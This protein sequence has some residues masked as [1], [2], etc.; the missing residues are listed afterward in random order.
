MLTSVLCRARRKN[1]KKLAKEEWYVEGFIWESAGG[2]FIIPDGY[3]I[4]YDYRTEVMTAK[5]I[6][7][8]KNTISQYTDLNDKNKK[9][10][11]ENDVVKTKSGIT[12]RVVWHSDSAAFCLLPDNDEDEFLLLSYW[13]NEDEI[14]VIGN[15]FDN[16]V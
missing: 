13:V 7:I 8:D 1:W 3:G 11:Y 14:E 6:E 4:C 16:P 2:A 9:M 5:A 12:G 10:I 15:V